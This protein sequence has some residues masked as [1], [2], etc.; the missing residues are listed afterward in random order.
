MWT[1]SLNFWLFYI[2]YKILYLLKT[3]TSLENFFLILLNFSLLNF[4]FNFSEF[5]LYSKYFIHFPFMDEIISL[6]LK[7]NENTLKI[8]EH[9]NLE[10]I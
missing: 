8:Q 7:K 4:Y 5:F 3:I 10:F 1:E 2:M 9:K 6:N